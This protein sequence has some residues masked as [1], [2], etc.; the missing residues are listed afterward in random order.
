MWRMAGSIRV[1]TDVCAVIDDDGAVLLDVRGGKYFSLNGVG[2]LIWQEL[3]AGKAP[4]DIATQLSARFGVPAVDV[5]SDVD[6]FITR[7]RS[8]RLLDAH[9]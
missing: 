7:L 6:E 1:P 5:Q 4:S 9:D 8:K 3:A 2:A